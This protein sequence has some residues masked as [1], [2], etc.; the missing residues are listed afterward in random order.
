MKVWRERSKGLKTDAFTL[1][2]LLVVVAIIGILVSLAFPVISRVRTSAKKTAARSD[3]NSLETAVEQYYAAYRHMPIADE[4]HQ[5]EESEIWD[6]EDPE[7]ELRDELRTA[8]MRAVSAL[9]GSNRSGLNPR[10]EQFLQT[11][12]GRP[13]GHFL[14]PWSKGLDLTADSDNRLYRLLFD[15]NLDKVIQI[16]NLIG[17]SD[18]KIEGRRVVVQCCGPNREIDEIGDNDFDDLYNLDIDNILKHR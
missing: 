9:Q 10:Q 12:E 18:Y 17:L 11:Q 13:I 4:I 3:M 8:I 5:R 14:D 6:P 2:E 7:A 1:I 16:S 15:H